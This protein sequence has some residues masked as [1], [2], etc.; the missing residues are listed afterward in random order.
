MRS[1]SSLSEIVQE[2]LWEK[3]LGKVTSESSKHRA[4]LEHDSLSGN[5]SVDQELDVGKGQSWREWVAVNGTVCVRL[6]R[7]GQSRMLLGV[8]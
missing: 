7:S 8:A 3:R 1:G 5:T 2:S 6:K 4:H